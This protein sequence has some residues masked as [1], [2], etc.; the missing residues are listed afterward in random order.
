MTSLITSDASHLDGEVLIP[1]ADLVPRSIFRAHIIEATKDVAEESTAHQDYI[2][3]SV[4]QPV[5]HGRFGWMAGAPL[6]CSPEFPVDIGFPWGVI[7]QD[8][9][10]IPQLIAGTSRGGRVFPAELKA[11][12]N[13]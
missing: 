11:M 7:G 3:S 9:N 5:L 4:N 2:A 8:R 12:F 6:V 13:F 10:E 1:E